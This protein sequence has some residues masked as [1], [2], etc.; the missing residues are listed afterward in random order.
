MN[1]E[2]YKSTVLRPRDP[3][4]KNAAQESDRIGA[5]KC[6]AADAAFRGMQGQESPKTE[7]LT[8]TQKRCSGMKTGEDFDHA[9]PVGNGRIGAM[10][11]GGA[12]DEVLKLNEDSIW[13][14]GKRNRN[15]PDA[16]R[17]GKSGS[18]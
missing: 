1:P 10:I 6:W 15:N 3:P 5:E 14:G 4:S 18:C 7:D 13:S 11:F 16:R 17:A 8:W 12:A 2:T 9:L